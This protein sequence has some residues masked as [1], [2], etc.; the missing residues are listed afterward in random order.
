MIYIVPGDPIPLMRPRISY[1]RKMYDAQQ[2]A[3]LVYGIHVQNQHNE[4][5]LLDGPLHLDVTFF[6]NMNN[7]PK[8]LKPLKENTLHYGRPDLDNLIKFVC[9]IGTS[10]IYKDD[11][12]VSSI[13]A[14]KIYAYEPR[15]E[16]SITPINRDKKHENYK[17]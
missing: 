7:V 5:P 15:T 14:R 8:K 3:K 11:A 10:I 1:Q 13:S 12:Q 16:F 4:K 17:T 6:M 9:E 2:S